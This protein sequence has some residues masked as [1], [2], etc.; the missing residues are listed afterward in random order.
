MQ[1]IDHLRLISTLVVS[2]TG[3][4]TLNSNTIAI[5]NTTGITAGQVV[6][7]TGIAPNTIV[8]TV[9]PTSITISNPGHSAPGSERLKFDNFT[10][11]GPQG[12]PFTI[13]FGGPLANSD[14]GDIGSTK[15]EIASAVTVVDGTPLR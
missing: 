12:G 6:T 10:L 14:Q 11:T 8:T 5:A 7:G 13:V 15:P 1:V 9:S 2:A 4:L 3:T